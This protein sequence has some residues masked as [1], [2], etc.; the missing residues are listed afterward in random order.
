MISRYEASTTV[1]GGEQ[2]H[3]INELSTRVP[4]REASEMSKDTFI[5]RPR[6]CPIISHFC[7]K[8]VLVSWKF[9]Y[10]L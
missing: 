8:L 6:R 2:G 5:Q 1:M 10:R 9:I 7:E 3:L 4:I